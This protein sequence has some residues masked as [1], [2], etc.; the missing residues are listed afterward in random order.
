MG[1]TGR[2]CCAVL[3]LFWN[4]PAESRPAAFSSLLL[5]ASHA[6]PPSITA[7]FPFFRTSQTSRLVPPCQANNAAQTISCRTHPS[8]T[9]GLPTLVSSRSSRSS[10]THTHTPPLHHPLSVPL[11][12]I[13]LCL[14]HPTQTPNSQL[15]AQPSLSSFHIKEKKPASQSILAMSRQPRNAP[16]APAAS[17]TRMNEYFVPRDGIDREVISADICRYLGNDALV[18]PGHYE[19]PQTGQTVQGYYITAY[20]N[21]TTAMIEDLKADSA[22][23]DSE[24]RSQTSRSAHGG[25]HG[26]RDGPNYAGAPSSNSHVV[27][28][29]YSETHQSRQHLGPTEH[30]PFQQQQQQQ[31]QDHFNSRESFDTA[32]YPGSGAP[33]YTGATGNFPQ[34]QTYAPATTGPSYGNYQQGP[35]AGNPDPRY[36]SPVNQPGLMNPGFQAQEVPYVN[37]GANMAPRYPPNDGFP[38]PRGGSSGPGPQQP[39]YSTS[40][41]PQQGYSQPPG[42]PFQYSNQGPHPG[43]NQQYSSSIQPQDP[44]YGRGPPP[45]Y[46]AQGQ[47]QPQQQP[48]QYE[49]TPL[50]RGSAPPSSPKPPS[51]TNKRRSDQD[52]DRNSVERHHRPPPPRR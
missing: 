4:T 39:M 42:A 33:G 26:S 32:R 52:S 24:R 9:D 40:G 31:Q 1:W 46:G 45:P 6:A 3:C 22:R 35:P 27:Q 36:A 19:N 41:P 48:Q 2:K 11:A 25:I 17:S 15:A 34:Q 44:F 7:R 21:L 20:R 47:Q 43:S 50:A 23:W 37:T 38:G 5:P 16:P 18:R 14:W 49:E 10:R 13:R 30:P 8:P 28:Y 12:I 51:G 29:R